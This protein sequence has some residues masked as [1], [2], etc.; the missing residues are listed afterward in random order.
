MLESGN[1]SS[2][3]FPVSLNQSSSRKKLHWNRDSPALEESGDTFESVTGE[4]FGALKYMTIKLNEGLTIFV[5]IG[6]A[7]MF[8]TQK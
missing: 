4:M 6:W 3:T 2:V 5:E 1:F 7:K 8:C